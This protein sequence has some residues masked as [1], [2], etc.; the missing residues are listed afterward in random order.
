MNDEMLKNERKA[1]EYVYETLG[2]PEFLTV[3]M[4]EIILGIE[5]C[6]YLECAFAKSSDDDEEDMYPI[7]VIRYD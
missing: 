1:A 7:G 4:I 6:Y 2:R 3:E 5:T